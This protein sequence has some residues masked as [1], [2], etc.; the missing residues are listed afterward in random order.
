[1]D[2][3]TEISLGI[4]LRFSLFIVFLDEGLFLILWF[5]TLLAAAIVL[6]SGISKIVGEKR[7]NCVILERSILVDEDVLL[8]VRVFYVL[9]T[10]DSGVRLVVS[11]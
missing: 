6:K 3:G 9:A 10:Y 1:L 8:V 2:R 5:A 4:P 11:R 7:E